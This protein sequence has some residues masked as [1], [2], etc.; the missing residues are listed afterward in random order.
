MGGISAWE[1]YHKTFCA[2]LVLYLIGISAIVRANV[3]YID[4]VRRMASGQ[5]NFGFGRKLADALAVLVHADKIARDVSPLTQL[6]AVCFLA[7]AGCIVIHLVTEKRGFDLW[8]VIAVLPLGLSPYF[9][10]CLS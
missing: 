5:R 3:P 6:L 1:D 4:D 9:L 10:E 7:A 8:P 2:L